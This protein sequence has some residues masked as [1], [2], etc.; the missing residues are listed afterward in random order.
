MLVK[1]NDKD[2][3]IPIFWEFEPV[4]QM[5]HHPNIFNV[6]P[7]M[8]EYNYGYR[9]NNNRGLLDNLFHHDIEFFMF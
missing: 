9:L 3:Y 7:F 1:R 8:H 5:E 2:E 6:H 4:L